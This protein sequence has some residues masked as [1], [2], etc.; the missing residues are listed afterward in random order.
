MAN[1]PLFIALLLTLAKCCIGQSMCTL[2][3]GEEQ[4]RG[5]PVIFGQEVRVPDLNLR[6]ID[7]GTRTPISPKKVEVHYYWQWIMY[8]AAEHAWGAWADGQDRVR[9]EPAGRVEITVP[10][11]T[12]K[13]RGWYSGKYTSFPWPKKPHFARIEIVIEFDRWAPRLM[14]DA[15]D[16]NKYRGTTAIVRLPRAGRATVVF[17]QKK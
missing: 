14:I 4:T 5:E 2:L 6:F 9:C 1:G 8:P 16:L 13:P 17:E 15:S 10:A 7:A 11:F 3:S 12:V